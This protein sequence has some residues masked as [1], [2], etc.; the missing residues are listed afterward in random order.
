MA[1][2]NNI[3]NLELETRV[4]CDYF[5]VILEQKILRGQTTVLFP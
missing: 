1:K 3:Y 2:K 5:D 4:K